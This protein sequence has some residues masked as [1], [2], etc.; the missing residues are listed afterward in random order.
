MRP[1]FNLRSYGMHILISLESSWI[2][3]PDLDLGLDI[4]VY[5]EVEG[6]KFRRAVPL[7]AL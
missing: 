4:D 1:E 3:H 2:R 6:T 5:V 7:M